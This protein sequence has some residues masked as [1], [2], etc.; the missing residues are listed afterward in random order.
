MTAG[1]RWLLVVACALLSSADAWTAEEVPE[2]PSP[3]RTDWEAQGDW[4]V[5]TAHR[6]Q[7]RKPAAEGWTLAQDPTAGWVIARRAPAGSVE[8]LCEVRDTSAAARQMARAALDHAYGRTDEPHYFLPQARFRQRQTRFQ[9][10]GA[11][12]VWIEGPYSTGVWRADTYL[13]FRRKQWLVILRAT[14]APQGVYQAH[15]QAIEEI[16]NSLTWF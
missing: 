8:V 4:L 7:V 2:A 12:R 10:A 9:R 6:C 5:N 3:A 14:A 13:I 11:I 16:F 1:R 15:Q